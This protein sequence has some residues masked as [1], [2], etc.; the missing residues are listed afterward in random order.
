LKP[1]VAVRIRSVSKEIVESTKN[2]PQRNL[3]LLFS[4]SLIQPDYNDMP[5]DK[6]EKH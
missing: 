2:L 3:K 6:L 4:F 5:G 1:Q